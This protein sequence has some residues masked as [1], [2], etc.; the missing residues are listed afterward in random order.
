MTKQQWVEIANALH[1]HDW[2]EVTFATHSHDGE[3][4]TKEVRAL[5]LSKM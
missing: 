5:R 3:H 4:L 1:R 2:L